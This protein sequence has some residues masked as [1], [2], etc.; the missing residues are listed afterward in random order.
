M[1]NAK[2]M[3]P[4]KSVTLDQM[5]RAIKEELFDLE[6]IEREEGESAASA[7]SYDLD[8]MFASLGRMYYR[9]HKDDR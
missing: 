1:A 3:Y 4:N 7:S 6:R 5:V 8:V 2:F 9:M